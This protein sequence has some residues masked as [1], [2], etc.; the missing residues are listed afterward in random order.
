MK[1]FIVI[2]L[3]IP[4]LIYSIFFIILNKKIFKNK[5]I[6]VSYIP[7][8]GHQCIGFYSMNYLRKS[9]EKVTILQIIYN[10]NNNQLSNFFKKIDDFIL[11]R[12]NSSTL[13]NLLGKFIYKFLIYLC[14]NKNN[15]I[16]NYNDLINIQKKKFLKRDDYFVKFYSYK[17]KKV[18][19]DY[20]NFYWLDLMIKQNK[21]KLDLYNNLFN[22][23]KKKY[24]FKDK[25]VSIIFRDN[26]SNDK[27][28]KI[29]SFNP[30]NYSLAINW[31]VKN[32][33][34]VINHNKNYNKF[35][36]KFNKT[37]NLS[38]IFFKNLDHSFLNLLLLYKSNMLIS[39]HSGIHLFS[40]I[41]NIKTIICDAFPFCSGISNKE[42]II[43]FKNVLFK[44]NTLKVKNILKHEDLF[45]G[46]VG[47]NYKIKNNSK[48]QILNA[49][50]LKKK[51][52]IKFPK[53]SLISFR[54]N[55]IIEN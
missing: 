33:Y 16:L 2:I 47:R 54:N 29:R 3:S 34:T 9:K 7:S 41:F 36:S 18:S 26:Y 15:I 1:K 22:K 43:L 48:E 37:L 19:K 38:D 42:N 39:Q 6:F 20:E 53:E 45:Y 30:L 11:F 44:N 5:Y 55:W 13:N 23:I 31:L 35:F 21:I 12:S 24:K 27:Y 52:K 17:N 51:I 46:K 8:F 10:R 25:I 14:K 4:I 50:K 49:V 32:G 28:D 40:V